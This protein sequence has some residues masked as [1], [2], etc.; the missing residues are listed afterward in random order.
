M[1]RAVGSALEYAMAYGSLAAAGVSVAALAVLLLIG[2][3]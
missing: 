3:A 2:L 1:L